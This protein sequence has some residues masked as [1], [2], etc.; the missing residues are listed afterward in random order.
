MLFAAYARSLPID[1]AYQNFDEECASLPG[2]YAPPRGALLLARDTGGAAIGCVAL[3]PLPPEGIC[4]MK[5]LYVAP[6]GR[7]AGA[8]RALAEKI[9][10][11]A[12]IIGYREMR[13]DTLPSM[14]AALELYRSLGFAEIAPYYDTPVVGTIFM[15]LDLAAP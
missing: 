2:A 7:G 15:A 13:L 14:R 8:G 12:R 5:R 1:L 4:E 10:S 11:I 9:V 3:R 6:A